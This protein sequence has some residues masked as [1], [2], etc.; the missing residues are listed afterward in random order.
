M[1]L[2]GRV[3]QSASPISYCQMKHGNLSR[4]L[5]EASAGESGQF[6]Y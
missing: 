6:H 5:Q 4:Y 2:P 3:N 1:S